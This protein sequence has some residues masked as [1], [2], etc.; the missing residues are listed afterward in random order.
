MDNIDELI[1]RST[2]GE[3]EALDELF[4]LAKKADEASQFQDATRLYREAAIS[5]R[6]SA[7]RERSHSEEAR[8][9]AQAVTDEL[10]LIEHM[11]QRTGAISML[12]S[13]SLHVDREAIREI[14][15]EDSSFESATQQTLPLLE[16]RL[17][18]LGLHFSSPGGSI[19]RKLTVLLWTLYSGVV[20][21]QEHALWQKDPIVRLAVQYI[22]SLLEERLHKLGNNT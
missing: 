5:F 18:K 14:V 17:S 12:G 3:R 20:E 16:G 13:K 19:E 2:K 4:S 6:I 10:T 15:I 21:T 9:V 7:S 1:R 22:S 11:L 8:S